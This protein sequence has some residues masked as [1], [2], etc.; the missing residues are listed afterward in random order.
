VEEEK[1]NAESQVETITLVLLVLAGGI[2]LLTGNLFE[3]LGLFVLG[4]ILLGSAVY[5]S[6][7][8]WPVSLITWILAV[9][10]TLGGLGLKIFVVAVLQVNWLAIGLGLIVA[11][12]LYRT[13][14]RRR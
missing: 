4:V 14:F 9:L 10:L 7:R 8:G 5:Q 11:W 2:F 6:L 3:P 13:L 1:S 12:G